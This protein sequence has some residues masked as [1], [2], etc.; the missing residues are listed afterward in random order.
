[1]ASV[2]FIDTNVIASWVIVKSNL[3]RLLSEEYSLPSEYHTLYEDK[4]KEDVEF[5]DRILNSDND[6]FFEKYEIY[7]S[8]LATNE[9]FSAIRDEVLSLKLFHKGE[10]VSRWPGAKNSIK[11]N[12]DEAKFIYDTAF[13][14]WDIL[15]DGKIV[16]LNDDPGIESHLTETKTIDSTY[17]DVYAPLLFTIDNAKTQD[18]MLIT[19]AIMNEADVF[20]TRDERLINSVKK[21]LK[22]EYELEII[23]P[24][25]ANLRMK[26]ELNSRN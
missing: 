19:T 5:I 18:I 24:N 8:F 16:V 23:K 22:E 3:L 17:W 21:V 25:T 10:P 6:K 14:V 20:V 15:F 13:G 4:F 11:L 9:L 26:N 2:W 7:F 12:P 1:M